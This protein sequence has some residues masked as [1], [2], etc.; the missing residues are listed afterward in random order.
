MH[1]A[2]GLKTDKNPKPTLFLGSESKK[3]KRRTLFREPLEKNVREGDI[4]P[5]TSTFKKRKY[6]CKQIL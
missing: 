2:D 4:T 3:K 5:A 6:P 1:F